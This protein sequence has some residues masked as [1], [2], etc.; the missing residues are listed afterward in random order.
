MGSVPQVLLIVSITPSTMFQLIQRPPSRSLSVLGNRGFELECHRQVGPVCQM[1]HLWRLCARCL[2][3][4][5]F[6]F[7]LFFFF[8]F[9]PIMQ[10]FTWTVN[11]LCRRLM[12]WCLPGPWFGACLCVCLACFLWDNAV[13]STIGLV[14]QDNNDISVNPLF[15]S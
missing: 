12:C 15:P 8:F 14:Q 9:S 6:S 11:Y 4:I 5:L 7:A 2:K 3:L 13:S 1:D 10:P